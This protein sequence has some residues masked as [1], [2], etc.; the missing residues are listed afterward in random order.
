MM[1]SN[2]SNW[3]SPDGKL[4]WGFNGEEHNKLKKSASFGF[5]SGNGTKPQTAMAPS[6]L[7][8]PDVSWVHSLV[9]D[10]SSVGTGLYSSEHRH[11][12]FNETLP[13][14]VEQLYIEQEQIMA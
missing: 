13:P 2:L 6:S 11:G 8:E 4:D 1:S 12:G 5:R 3:S 7:D 10:V 9:K 14:W